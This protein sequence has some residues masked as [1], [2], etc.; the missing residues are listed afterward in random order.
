MNTA[1]EY[2]NVNELVE[3]INGFDPL[4]MAMFVFDC[5]N[6]PNIIREKCTFEPRIFQINSCNTDQESLVSTLIENSYFTRFFIQGLT[7]AVDRNQKCF[8]G[9]DKCLLC[10]ER[11]PAKKDY[12]TVLSLFEYVDAHMKAKRESSGKHISVDWKPVLSVV[13]LDRETAIVAYSYVSNVQMKFIVHLPGKP[14]EVRILAQT[15]GVE[16]RS[17]YPDYFIDFN[18]IK[19]KLL[20]EFLGKFIPFIY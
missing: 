8:L 11:R 16:S 14:P 2:L 17:I 18:E 4:Q 20:G 7:Q 13:D 3:H 15:R 9:N 12:I 19:R 5:C 6:A 1:A 10:E